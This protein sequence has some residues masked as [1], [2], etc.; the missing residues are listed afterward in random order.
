MFSLHLN[1]CL[2]DFPLVVIVCPALILLPM[3]L[4]S[5]WFVH[6]FV[7][8]VTFHLACS[9]QFHVFL[10]KLI[11]I[12]LAFLL[13]AS[14]FCTAFGFGLLNPPCDNVCMSKRIIRWHQYL[15]DVLLGIQGRAVLDVVQFYRIFVIHCKQD[16]Q[17][18]STSL[19]LNKYVLPA[20]KHSSQ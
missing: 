13:F 18:L 14:V 16:F 1:S 11:L 5:S 8:F 12:K 19:T 17:R 15:V 20:S 3:F 4:K 9:P 10:Y 2:C 7:F 6:P